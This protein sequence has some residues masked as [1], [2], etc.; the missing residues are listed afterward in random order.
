MSPPALSIVVTGRNDNYGG[1]FNERF[2]TALR[3][4]YERLTERGVACE[5]ILAEW[6]PVPDRPTLSELLVKEFS[7]LPE[8]VLRPFVIAPEYHT[9]FTQNPQLG[10]LEYVAKNAGIRRAS[11]PLVLVTNTDV[12]IGREAVEAIAT[13]RIAPGTIYRAARYDLKIGVDRSHIAWDALEDPANHVRRPVLQPPLFTGGSGDFVLADRDT[14]NDLR[15]FNEVYRVARA[16]VDVNFLVKAYGAGV[17]IADIGGP[18]YHVNHVGSFRITKGRP[19]EDRSNTTWG[20]RWHCRDVA[21]NNPDGWG[22]AGAPERA[23]SNGVTY[24]DFDW[25]AVPPLVDLRRIVL[26]VRQATAESL[27]AGV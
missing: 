23:I 14:F 26:P 16:G 4:N 7:G 3:F 8:H 21:Y 24:L 12:F 11:S 9:A 22:L 13:E 2:F 5:V 19:D 15:G 25:K 6:N 18:V 20:H 17:P 1:D 27:P 10:Y